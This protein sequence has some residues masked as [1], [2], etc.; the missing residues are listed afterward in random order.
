MR[1]ESAPP[2]QLLTAVRTDRLRKEKCVRA[3]LERCMAETFREP[4]AA[5][6]LC[7]EA[8]EY[9]RRCKQKLGSRYP[10]SLVLAY[11]IV[12]TALGLCGSYSM[13]REAFRAGSQITGASDLE[14]AGLKIR[15]ARI[16]LRRERYH[17]ALKL[18]NETVQ[19]LESQEPQTVRDD[20]NPAIPFIYRAV[21]NGNIMNFTDDP[22][23]VTP[24]SVFR[25]FELGLQLAPVGCARTRASAIHGICYT[26]ATLWLGGYMT[27]D[28]TPVMVME[29]ALRFRE[30]LR[31]EGTP[32]SSPIDAKVRWTLGLSMFQL[33]GG[34]GRGAEKHFREA[35][36]VLSF[37]AT[38]KDIAAITLDLQWCL[39]AD[40]RWTAALDEC[41]VLEETLGQEGTILMWANALR[42]RIIPSEVIG[43]VYSKWRGLRRVAMPVADE[44]SDSDPIGF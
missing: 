28:V 8:P 4:R 38:E 34:L 1:I 5:I 19:T 18:V 33:F 9:V 20:L 22:G 43:N 13:S 37:G 30:R 11:G 12:G 39:L 16:E 3:Y 21:I 27:K 31:K 25:D 35:R 40:G 10:D 26:A 6:D 15:C 32:Y 41:K 14:L 44:E 2:A 42:N 7:L 36:K 24:D 23:R 29:T 17:Y